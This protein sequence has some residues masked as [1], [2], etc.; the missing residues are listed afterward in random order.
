MCSSAT[1]LLQ[2]QCQLFP[3]ALWLTGNQFLFLLTPPL[4]RLHPVSFLLQTLSLLQLQPWQGVKQ[5]HG[6][7]RTFKSKTNFKWWQHNTITSR[8][9]NHIYSSFSKIQ[10]SST[11]TIIAWEPT[12][13][14]HDLV[15]MLVKYYWT[16]TFIRVKSLRLM[17]PAV[18][19]KFSYSNVKSTLLVF[20]VTKRNQVGHS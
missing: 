7:L 12:Y 1:H 15:M 9:H 6:Y 2:L 8:F 11:P 18:V 20:F 3:L 13:H 19:V 4:Q 10:T 16:H 17:F 5:E 14:W